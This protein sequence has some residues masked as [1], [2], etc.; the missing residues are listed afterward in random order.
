[1]ESGLLDA[2]RGAACQR[3]YSDE[4]RSSH[5]VPSDSSARAHTLRQAMGPLAGRR[6]E[7]RTIRCD[8][9]KKPLR[10]MLPALNESAKSNP[11]RSLAD[12]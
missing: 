8:A 10:K 6:Q 4:D 1:M 9:A 11:E 12:S 5:R 3:E 7:H 2:L